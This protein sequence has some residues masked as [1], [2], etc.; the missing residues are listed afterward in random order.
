MLD[1]RTERCILINFVIK[2]KVCHFGTTKKCVSKKG[3]VIGERCVILN[4]V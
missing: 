2:K 3:Y 4:G 1:L